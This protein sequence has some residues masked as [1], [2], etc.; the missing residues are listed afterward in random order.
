MYKIL[1]LSGTYSRACH[2]NDGYTVQNP[3]LFHVKYIENPQLGVR[4]YVKP[5]EYPTI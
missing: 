1:K 4:T 2:S 3:F 5:V